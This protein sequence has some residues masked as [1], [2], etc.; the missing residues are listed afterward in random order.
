MKAEYLV[1]PDTQAGYHI[2]HREIH[3]DEGL[4]YETWSSQTRKWKTSQSALDAFVSLESWAEPIEES[5]VMRIIAQHT[6]DDSR[7]HQ[8]VAAPERVTA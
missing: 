3:D 6:E 4:S 2:F 1:D 7:T 8:H 5:E